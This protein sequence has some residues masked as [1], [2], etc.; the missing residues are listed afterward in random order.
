V[1]PSKG[2]RKESKNSKGL[3]KLISIDLCVSLLHSIFWV[4]FSVLINYMHFITI[5][6]LVLFESIV[7][8]FFTNPMKQ[9]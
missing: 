2:D 5:Y 8:L 1:D 9:T 3:L 7:F 4:Y 6:M